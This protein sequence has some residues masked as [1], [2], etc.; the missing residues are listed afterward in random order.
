MQCCHLPPVVSNSSR[1]GRAPLLPKLPVALHGQDEAAAVS[2]RLTTPL[3]QAAG[4][5]AAPLQ[6]AS[7]LGHEGAFPLPALR[8]KT[9]RRAGFLGLSLVC[10]IA[11]LK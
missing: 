10:F 9:Q 5:G 6:G 2:A 3:V 4:G 1:P 11:Q 7:V 8:N